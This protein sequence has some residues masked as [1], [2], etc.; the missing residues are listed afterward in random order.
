MKM[1][2]NAILRSDTFDYYHSKWMHAV[3]RENE[4]ISKSEYLVT[5]DGFNE[6]AALVDIC[7]RD[8]FSLINELDG[9]YRRLQNNEPGCAE[10][11]QLFGAG[12]FVRA[13]IDNPTRMKLTLEAL[14][15]HK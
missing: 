7:T 15:A 8:I 14:I 12:L 1:E 11:A 9:N 4:K 3:G 10:M 6:V 5:D 2:W 13:L